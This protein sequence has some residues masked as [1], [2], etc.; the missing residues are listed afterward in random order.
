MMSQEELND[1]TP[2][3]TEGTGA[4]TEV[5]GISPEK[6][7]EIERKIDITEVV[8]AS[9]EAGASGQYVPP[10]GA[11]ISEPFLPGDV[12]REKTGTQKMTVESVEDS[13]VAVVYF[14]EKGVVKRDVIHQDK[15][16]KV[17]MEEP[18]PREKV[19]LGEGQ[20]YKQIPAPINPPTKGVV[21]ELK[22]Q[23]EIANPPT[24]SY[25]DSFKFSVDKSMTAIM[26]K[27]EELA[28]EY[29]GENM[30]MHDQLLDA[31]RRARKFNGLIQRM[32]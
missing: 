22:K 17:T 31:A 26:I 20:L 23:Q 8:S 32:K 11:G 24:Q 12:V 16:M 2:P 15:L 27:L 4:P 5:P 9:K 21:E 3:Q 7:A 13:K 6:L 30:P 14:D 18:V 19:T 28:T 10:M 25:L 29:K 1:F